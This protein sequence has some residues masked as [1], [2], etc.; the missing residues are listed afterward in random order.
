MQLDRYGFDADIDDIPAVIDWLRQHPLID[1]ELPEPKTRVTEQRPLQEAFKRTVS[2]AWD[3]KCPI[4]GCDIPELLEAAH[5]HGEGSWRNRNDA[6]DGILLRVDLH[7]LF[8]AGL[9]VIEQDGKVSCAV[10]GYEWT[11]A[12]IIMWPSE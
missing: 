6:R 2:D 9:L 1:F 3:G 5:R 10:R 8:G 4:S 7:R 11:D 12:N